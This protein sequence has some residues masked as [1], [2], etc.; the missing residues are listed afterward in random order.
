MFSK[1]PLLPGQVCQAMGRAGKDKS[2]QTSKE[3]TAERAGHASM[4]WT[5]VTPS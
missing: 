4:A 3:V 1:V 2:P 5:S